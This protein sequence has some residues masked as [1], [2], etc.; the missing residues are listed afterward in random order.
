[1]DHTF[2]VRPPDEQ[3]PGETQ[4]VFFGRRIVAEAIIVPSGAAEQDKNRD[5]VSISSRLD[6]TPFRQIGARTSTVKQIDVDVFPNRTSR[7]E[8]RC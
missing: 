1:M 8:E 7:A 5:N 4:A 6:R 3:D 2:R